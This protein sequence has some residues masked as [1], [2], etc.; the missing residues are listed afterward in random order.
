LSNAQ[1]PTPSAQ[2]R[3]EIRPRRRILWLK[4]IERFAVC[5]C[6][7]MESSEAG[8]NCPLK[9]RGKSPSASPAAEVFGAAAAGNVDAFGTS[10]AD[11]KTLRP[12]GIVTVTRFRGNFGP[13]RVQW[14]HA[15]E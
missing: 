2:I 13:T 3:S 1:F 12:V 11:S 9:I 8:R 4:P 5:G 10:M 15:S 7:V 6:F 14:D